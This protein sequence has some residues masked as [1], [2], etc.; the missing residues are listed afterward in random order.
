MARRARLAGARRS[1]WISSL[2]RSGSPIVNS[3]SS[4][5]DRV[6]EDHARCG[7][8][9][10]RSIS[11][12]G[13]RQQVACPRTARGR[14]RSARADRSAAGS[15]ARCTTCRSRSRRR[16]TSTRPE[17]QRERHAV[18]RAQGAGIELEDRCAGLRR[19]SSASAEVAIVIPACARGIEHRGQAVAE[20][21]EGERDQADEDARKDRDVRRRAS[22]RRGRRS[23][24]CP[25]P[26]PAAGCRGRGS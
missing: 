19:R 2:R 16:C 4:E 12:F 14:R 3:G 5:V 21:V 25:N 7:C 9:G 22:A 17:R 1:W 26:P 18:D 10:Q 23:P 20:E 11:R 13:E 24:W 15:R 8:R 6:L